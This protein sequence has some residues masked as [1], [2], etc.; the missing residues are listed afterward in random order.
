VG[1]VAPVNPD[2]L[3]A[4]DTTDTA[5]GDGAS[6]DGARVSLSGPSNRPD[7]LAGPGAALVCSSARSGSLSAGWAIVKK[8]GLDPGPVTLR[9]DLATVPHRA[10]PCDRRRRFRPHRHRLPAP[11]LHPVVIEHGRRRVHLAG[12]TAH[13]HWRLAHPA[14][15]QPAHGPRRPR[16][17]DRD[18]DHPRSRCAVRTGLQHIPVNRP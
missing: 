16:R 7:R 9:A 12:L 18:I 14:G 8:A 17:A 3:G 4:A 11:P 13:P 5:S 1:L 6:G 10:G 15:P 2:P